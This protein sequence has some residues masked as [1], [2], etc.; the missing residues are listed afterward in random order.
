MN[1]P[2]RP[3]LWVVGP[4]LLAMLAGC[5]STRPEPGEISQAQ[6]AIRDARDAGAESV[7][8]D[9]VAAAA[10]H[11]S[12]ARRAWS[13]GDE[14]LATH[15]ARLADSEARQ[16]EGLARANQAQ[17]ELDSLRQRKTQLS[18]QIREAQGRLDSARSD[19]AARAQQ[20]A[21]R[22]Q[23]EQARLQQEVAD[24]DAARQAAED[25]ERALREQLDLERQRTAEQQRQSEIERLTAEL[26]AQRKAAEEA[27]LAAQRERAELEKAR[28]AEEARRQ[29]AEQQSQAQ[30]D[31][32]IRLQ[33]I[34]K[35]TR[36]EARGIVV[37]LPGN[38]YFATGR[39]DLQPGIREHLVEIGKTLAAAPDRHVLIEGH[40]DSTGRAEF[41]LKL[42]G[43][44]AESVKSV[45][46]ANGVSPDRIEVHGYG[47]TKPV[48][49]NGTPAGRSQNRRVEIVVQAATSP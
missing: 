2:I 26:E 8:P 44:R 9:R 15:Y 39:A 31:L 40:T 13:N 14:A 42:S 48:A 22:L 19:A 27:R 21:I 29:A 30:A 18:A 20:E 47:A 34:E 37:T 1:R 3:F 7:A 49:S 45:L 46:V 11:L 43:L 38:I 6:L 23:Q 28:Q 16:A 12:A 32:L 10:E 33:Q 17:K 35:S 5:A 25:R 36:A 4:I 41:N 24:R